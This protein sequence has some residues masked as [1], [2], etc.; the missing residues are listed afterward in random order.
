[1]L[2]PERIWQGD[3]PT[4]TVS[5]MQ[6]ELAKEKPAE[7]VRLMTGL[8]VNGS[9][10]LAGGGVM[11]TQVGDAVLQSLLAQLDHRRDRGYP[12]RCGLCVPCPSRGLP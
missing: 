9:V 3:A 12:R 5:T 4:C 6:Y 10:T 11:Q 2:R 8:T 7:Y 1:M